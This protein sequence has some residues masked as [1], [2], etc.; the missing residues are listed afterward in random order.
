MEKQALLSAVKRWGRVRGAGTMPTCRRG[1]VSMY[2][3]SILLSYSYSSDSYFITT[4]SPITLSAQFLSVVR[5]NTSCG[6][7]LVMK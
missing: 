7:A 4:S 2:L 1:A 3:L 5:D 6:K